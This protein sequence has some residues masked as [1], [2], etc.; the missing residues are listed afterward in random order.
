MK[1]KEPAAHLVNW[2]RAAQSL[3]AQARQRVKPQILHSPTPRNASNGVV[4]ARWKSTEGDPRIPNRGDG[5]M[6]LGKFFLTAA[7]VETEE[8]SPAATRV[9]VQPTQTGGRRVRAEV[10][11]LLRGSGSVVRRGRMPRNR[12]RLHLQRAGKL[13]L[14]KL[15]VQREPGVDLGSRIQSFED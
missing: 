5:D 2:L 8:E 7:L 4:G 9:C 13:G 15:A 3:H 6:K 12:A 14:I 10:H 1:R 11:R